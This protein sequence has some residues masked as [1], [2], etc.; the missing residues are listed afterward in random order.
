MICWATCAEFHDLDPDEAPVFA[1]CEQAGVP[2]RRL[3]WQA[4]DD[5]PETGDIVIVRSTWNYHLHATEF[6]DWVR[7]T[8]SIAR[9]FNPAKVI[10]SN[11]YKR[12]LQA[13]PVRVVPTTFATSLEAVE[14]PTT[15]RFIIKPTIGAGSH[16]AQT[17]DRR[18]S[19][20]ESLVAQI[21]DEGAD[22][23]IQ[24]FVESVQTVGEHSLVYIDGE[25]TH[26]VIKSPR[27]HGEAGSTS[28][29]L[30]LDARDFAFGNAAIAPIRDQILYARVDIMEIDGEWALNELELI[31]PLLFLAQHPPALRRLVAWAKRASE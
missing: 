17:F 3:D 12:Y 30:A 14:W 23:M 9:L 20:A 2:I 13:Q 21:L 27:F 29:A 19:A 6:A 24:P 16:L 8:E 25:F 31:E 26:K 5:V 10:L 15:G 4:P 7:R 22:V 1:A 28:E 18:S 11:M